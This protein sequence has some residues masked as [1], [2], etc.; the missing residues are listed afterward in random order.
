M[1]VEYVEGADVG[2]RWYARTGREP[3]F[4]F[5][6]G[7]S[8]TEFRYGD[9]SLAGEGELSASVP[10]TNT[11]E[12]AGAD[13]VQV[14]LVSRA[15]TAMRRLTGFQRV[16]LAPG[17]TRTVQIPLE[18]RTQADWADEGW[19]LPA[20]DYTFAVAHSA[21]EL[22]STASISRSAQRLTPGG[23]PLGAPD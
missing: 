18:N 12:R 9:L 16:E 4:P 11:G 5:G 22:G 1:A 21:E 6:F 8:Y 19:V 23:R 2:Y 10:V 7:L 17:E 3:L 20:G 13:V 14:Y 15:G